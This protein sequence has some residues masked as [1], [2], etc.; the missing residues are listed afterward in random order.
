MNERSNSAKA[1]EAAHINRLKGIAE[2]LQEDVWT[3]EATREGVRLIVH[4]P[5]GELAHVATIHPDALDDERDLLCGALDHLRLFLRLFDRAAVTVRDLRGAL[6]SRDEAGPGEGRK[7]PDHAAQAAILLA[8]PA[9][10]QFLRAGGQPAVHDTDSADAAL[11]ARLG[12]TSKKQ[13][14]QEDRARAAWLSL[15]GEFEAWL[16]G[17]GDV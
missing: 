15:H 11:K 8:K 17:G 1:R 14:N 6:A 16:R 12:I 5:M 13:I 4:R 2:R 7:K 3:L 10:Q 9:F